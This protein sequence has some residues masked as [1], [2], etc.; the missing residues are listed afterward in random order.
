MIDYSKLPAL[1]T[2]KKAAEVMGVSRDFMY[3]ALNENE[4]PT[5]EIAGRRWVM[6]DP[7]LR[8]L[9]LSIDEKPLRLDAIKQK[10]LRLDT[11][12][13]ELITKLDL[14]IRTLQDIK[15]SLQAKTRQ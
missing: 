15:K 5:I 13:N 10:A 7:L 3:K 1:L 14:V 9:G 6:R 12:E 2:I 8:K 4:I 11:D